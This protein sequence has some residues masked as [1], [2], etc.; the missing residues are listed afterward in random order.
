MKRIP[1]RPQ[2][3]A[4][5]LHPSLK[6]IALK[7]FQLLWWTEVLPGVLGVNLKSLIKTP[8]LSYI[9]LRLGSAP[10]RPRI[11]GVPL[12]RVL[13]FFFLALSLLLRQKVLFQSETDAC[14]I[15]PGAQFHNLPSLPL[16]GALTRK[17]VNRDREICSAATLA[18]VGYN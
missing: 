12:G 4:F 7:P 14:R 11:D 5:P 18:T 3:R 1:M 8:S 17:Y 13:F 16:G 6:S 10:I 2:G 9:K 15:P